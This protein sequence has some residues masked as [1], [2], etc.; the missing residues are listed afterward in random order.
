MKSVRTS[1][2][3]M[4]L[5]LALW[6]ILT[7]GDLSSWMIGLPF[8]ALAIMLQPESASS[9]DTYSR[10]FS[11]SGLLQFSYVFIIESVRGGIDVS[12][13]V[14]KPEVNTAPVF[15]DYHMQLQRPY[16]QQLFISSISLLPGTLCADLDKKRLRIH[17]LDQHMETAEGIKRLESLVGKIFGETL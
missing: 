14:L 6:L 9:S 7:A 11:V 12:R 4:L 17:T 10:S 16:A 15:Y 2:K 3:W 13:R 8:I 5:L 1:A